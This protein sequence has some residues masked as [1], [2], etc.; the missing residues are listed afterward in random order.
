[1]LGFALGLWKKN[2]ARSWAASKSSRPQTDFRVF[3]LS[4]TG[5]EV[6]ESLGLDHEGLKKAGTGPSGG[7]DLRTIK[8]YK[9]QKETKDLANTITFNRFFRGFS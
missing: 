5:Q 9:H 2:S 3:F 6:A 4:F 8:R 7:L 1:M